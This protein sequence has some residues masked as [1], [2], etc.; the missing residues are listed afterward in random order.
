MKTV[1]NLKL[2]NR[3]AK[4]GQYT[5][6]GALVVLGG[7]LYISFTH[8]DL[9]V[10]SII[11]LLVGFFMSQVG[12][13]FTNRWGRKPR[14][15]EIIDKSL[16]GLGREFTAYHYVT[17]VSHLLVGPAGVWAILPYFLS[18]TVSYDKKRWRAKGGGFLQTYM[19][20]FGQENIGRPD[21]E[22]EAEI[23]SAR[24]YLSKMLPEGTELP[25]IQSLLLFAHPQI[26]LNNLEEAPIPALTPKDLKDFLREKS[27]EKS[28]SDSMLASLQAALP[29]AEK[30]E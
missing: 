4:I 28:I 24:R 29:Q 16:K 11:A 30:E 7:G 21:L 23:E 27:K 14:P 8:Q 3:N 5:S 25:P 18:G 2:I 26:E 6:M 19:R 22:S 1:T 10:Y 9:Y 15:D 12:I 17:P 13:Q 20:M